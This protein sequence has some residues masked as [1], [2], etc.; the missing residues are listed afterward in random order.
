MAIS[1][2]DILPLV[3]VLISSCASLV[4]AFSEDGWR[5]LYWLAAAVINATAT[6]GI[7]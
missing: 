3:V 6:W 2:S 4:Y 5:S 7:K 1:S